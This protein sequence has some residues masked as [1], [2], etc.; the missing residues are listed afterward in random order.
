M[1][2]VLLDDITSSFRVL[3]GRKGEKVTLISDHGDVL[4]VQGQNGRFPVHISHTDKQQD[5]NG[6]KYSN[7][8]V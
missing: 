6:R 2:L 3:Y 4:I 5:L 1:E 8:Q 7:D